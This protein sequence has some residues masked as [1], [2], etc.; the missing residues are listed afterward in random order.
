MGAR[1]LRSVCTPQSPELGD[2]LG[3]LE[4][5]EGS[6]HLSGQGR[7]A[8]VSCWQRWALLFPLLC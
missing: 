7:A 1:W 3:I 2:S 6:T 4:G 8:L 5:A